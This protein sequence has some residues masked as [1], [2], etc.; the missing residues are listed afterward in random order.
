MVGTIKDATGSFAGGLFA[1]AGFALMSAIVV[2]VGIPER[3]DRRV[4]AA[5]ESPAE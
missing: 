3:R 2:L 1:L 4:A 5:L